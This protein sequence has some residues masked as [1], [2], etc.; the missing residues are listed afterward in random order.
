N[1]AS[2]EDHEL[3]ETPRFLHSARG[4]SQVVATD[5]NFSEFFRCALIALK[6]KAVPGGSV[7]P[8]SENS[9]QSGFTTFGPGHFMEVVGS[10]HSSTRQAWYQKWN[11]NRFL[12]PEAMAGLVHNDILE[13]RNSPIDKSL[14]NNE[15]LKTKLKEHNYN[16]NELLGVDNP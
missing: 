4:I 7:G 3:D 12:R 11:V 9:R 16:N 13:G 1:G 10:A 15:L 2:A 14:L 8:Y 5:T 6:E